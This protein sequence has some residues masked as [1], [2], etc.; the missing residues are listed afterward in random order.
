M[1][2]LASTRHGGNAISD[3]WKNRVLQQA[4]Q[5]GPHHYRVAYRILRHDMDAQDVCQ[6]A[7]VKAL[8]AQQQIENPQALGSWLTRVIVNE[9][10]SLCRKRQRDHALHHQQDVAAVQKQDFADSIG[11]LENREWLMA[12]LERLDEPTRCVVVLR[13]MEGMTGQEVT[14]IMDCSASMVSRRLHQGLDQM[15]A[16]ITQEQSSEVNAQ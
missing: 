16:W 5:W 1:T 12:M 2:A 11:N 14:K 13:T 7:Y 6:K 8:G 10:L 15:R 4:Q 9:S 3:A